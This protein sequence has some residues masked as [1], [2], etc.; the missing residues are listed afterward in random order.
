VRA[1]LGWVAAFVGFIKW[2]LDTWSRG[3]IL[4]EWASEFPAISRFLIR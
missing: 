1:K 3:E 2:A 4:K